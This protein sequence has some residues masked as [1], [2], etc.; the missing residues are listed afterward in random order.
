[1]SAGSDWIVIRKT[2][3]HLDGTWVDRPFR[4]ATRLT[5][6]AGLAV[7]PTLGF[8][9]DDEK[10]VA[11][12]WEPERRRPDSVLFKVESTYGATPTDPAVPN[13]ITIEN[14]PGPTERHAIPPT[15]LG[16][17][18]VETPPGTFPPGTQG[19]IV[20]GPPEDIVG[21]LMDDL[22]PPEDKGEPKKGPGGPQV[23]PER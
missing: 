23:R 20:L 19:E 5:L 2:G 6:G 4:W 7:V 15:L 9:Q 11:E 18:I 16:M 10:G 8:E 1:M 17:P 12:V 21:M 3:T 13:T 22:C 14:T